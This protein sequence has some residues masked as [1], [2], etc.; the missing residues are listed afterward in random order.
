[1][2]GEIREEKGLSEMNELSREPEDEQRECLMSTASITMK[3]LQTT[4]IH[5][6]ILLHGCPSD[7][8]V[9]VGCF[10][11]GAAWSVFPGASKTP[12]HCGVIPCVFAVEMK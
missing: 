10:A 12:C 6:F 9:V 3:D 8:C 7:T 5:S 11:R 1:M 4:Y 2:E